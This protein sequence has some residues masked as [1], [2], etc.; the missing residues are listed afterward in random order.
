M[1][2]KADIDDIGA[3]ICCKNDRV[4]D[5]PQFTDTLL[6]QN[7]DR[8]YLGFRCCQGDDPGDM[9]AMSSSL[10][11]VKYSFVIGII[12]T[13]Y[14]VI[15]RNKTTGE[16]WMVAVDT[17]IEDRYDD[18][19]TII[20]TNTFVDLMCLFK[21]DRFWEPLLGITFGTAADGP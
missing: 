5:S 4:F 13:I 17:G 1:V 12:I 14:E 19:L 20:D 6:I 3:I 10:V 15:A 2:A 18:R 16:R 11:Y 21:T 8:H 9:S 7:S